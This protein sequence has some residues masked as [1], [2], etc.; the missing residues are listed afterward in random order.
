MGSKRGETLKGGETPLF[1]RKLANILGWGT[2]IM[3]VGLIGEGARGDHPIKTPKKRETEGLQKSENGPSMLQQ[4]GEA[5][6]AD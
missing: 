1:R 3:G 5:I 4:G 2:T 6:G